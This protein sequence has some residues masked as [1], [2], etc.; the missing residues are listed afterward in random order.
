MYLR[1]P[2]VTISQTFNTYITKYLSLLLFGKTPLFCQISSPLKEK[3]T[4][5]ISKSLFIRLSDSLFIK[6]PH[7]FVKNY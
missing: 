7:F 3:Y 5:G 1:L 4:F 6:N 2:K